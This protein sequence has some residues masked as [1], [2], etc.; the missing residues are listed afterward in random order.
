MSGAASG[1]SKDVKF[2]KR[3]D[4]IL[5]DKVEKH[6]KTAK[7]GRE[8]SLGMLKAVYRRGACAFSTS[9]R[10]NM[11]RD[12]W[13]MGRVDAF[14]KLLK[15]GSPAN[16]AYKSDNDLLPPAH[17][18]SSRSL[19]ASAVDDYADEMIVVLKDEDDY[20]SP[21]EAIFALTEF[22]GLGYEAEPSIRAAWIRGVNSGESPYSRAKNVAE[23]AYESSDADL[24]PKPEKGVLS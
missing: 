13:A 7:D 11:T 23:Y 4:D 19:S 8:A 10:P 17:P 5:R 24:L 21:E 16:P 14:L 22:L 3:T 1:M 6:N 12:H 18:R 9:H 15:S 2:S 20:E